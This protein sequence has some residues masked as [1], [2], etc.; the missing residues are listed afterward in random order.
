MKRWTSILVG[1][2]VG[3]AGTAVVT[4]QHGAA[5]QEYAPSPSAPRWQQQCQ[6]VDKYP[7]NRDRGPL[8][9]RIN[10]RLTS[11]GNEG[12]ELVSVPTPTQGHGGIWSE[13]ML[14]FKRPAP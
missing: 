5:A 14:C 4:L 12:W 10:Q 6:V 7:Q 1:V 9:Q 11:M 8:M 3:C 13:V 2:L